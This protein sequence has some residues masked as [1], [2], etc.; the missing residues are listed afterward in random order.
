MKMTMLTLVAMLIGGASANA[1]WT[2]TRFGTEPVG[3]NWTVHCDGQGATL[4]FKYDKAAGN[5][6]SYS[7]SKTVAGH[8]PSRNCGSDVTYWYES[9]TDV[10]GAKA[11]YTTS[12]TRV[13]VVHFLTLTNTQD[14]SANFSVRFTQN[15]ENDFA[16]V[17]KSASIGGAALAVQ[18][19]KC[20]QQ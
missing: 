9:S 6:A 20:V 16:V 11:E 12:A 2:G 18:D 1:A 4:D 10:A 8:C 13:D 15:Y 19:L 5:F 14:P 17:V 3:V 7:Y